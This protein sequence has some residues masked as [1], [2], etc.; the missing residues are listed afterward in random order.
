M[1]YELK[2]FS[3]NANRPLADEIA[4]YLRLPVSDAEVKPIAAVILRPGGPI[5][6]VVH[7]ADL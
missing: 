6:M 1:S 3:G 5:Q 7:K 2:L 4:Q